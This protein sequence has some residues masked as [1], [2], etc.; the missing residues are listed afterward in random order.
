MRLTGI[1]GGALMKLESYVRVDA[2]TFW[3]NGE[4][5]TKGPPSGITEEADT[6]FWG[7]LDCWLADL[8]NGLNGEGNIELS[9]LVGPSFV[10]CSSAVA[11]DIVG[12]PLHGTYKSVSSLITSSHSCYNFKL[13]V[14]GLL[15]FFL[16]R[17]VHY[18]AIISGLFVISSFCTWTLSVPPTCKSY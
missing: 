12:I 8:L 4:G 5:A 14:L 17:S 13:L 6:S 16:E 9:C 3:L 11:F 1:L 10:I 2:G 15:V 7:W 18:R